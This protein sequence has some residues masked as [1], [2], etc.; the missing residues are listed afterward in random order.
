MNDDRPYITLENDAILHSGFIFSTTLDS[1]SVKGHHFFSRIPFQ[2]ELVYFEIHEIIEKRKKGGKKI[3]K[4][5]NLS[6]LVHGKI[7]KDTVSLSV[8]CDGERNELV[9]EQQV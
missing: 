6:T 2:P 7:L 1:V 4:K 3:K 5:T 9:E 8:L